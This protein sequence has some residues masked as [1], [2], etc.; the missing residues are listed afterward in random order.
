[1]NQNLSTKLRDS[2]GIVGYH[3]QLRFLKRIVSQICGV[4]FQLRALRRTY[5][6][7]RLNRGVS[8]ETVSPIVGHASTRA[9]ETYYCRKDADSAKSEVLQAFTEVRNGPSAEKPLIEKRE[10]I[11][12][13][14]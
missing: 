5:G 12:G 8:I 14:G 3:V 6:Q 10:L 13:Y 4:D 7:V 2:L 9:T 1:M 11:T